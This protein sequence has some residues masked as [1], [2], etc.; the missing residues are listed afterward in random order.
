MGT[1]REKP[2][3]TGRACAMD[4]PDHLS[5]RQ[6]ANGKHTRASA[7]RRF[8]DSLT[9][10]SLPIRLSDTAAVQN[11]MFGNIAPARYR[12]VKLLVAP[13]DFPGKVV[14]GADLGD[15]VLANLA[16]GLQQRVIE[17]QDFDGSFLAQLM[18]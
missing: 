7:R 2:R 3:R 12:R 1:F 6:H 9:R 11:G 8:R 14:A 5:R 13:V 16:E 18:Q 15:N 10:R 4:T 17:L